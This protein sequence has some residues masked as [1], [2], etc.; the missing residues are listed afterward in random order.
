MSLSTDQPDE[1]TARVLGVAVAKA[2]GRDRVEG[3]IDA[4][5]EV[6]EVLCSVPT[7]VQVS[8]LLAA[9]ALMASPYRKHRDA[10]GDLVEFLAF[11]DEMVALNMIEFGVDPW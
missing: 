11:S 9:V 4:V 5:D 7:D 8:A 10:Y 6:L 1:L 2:I 3:D